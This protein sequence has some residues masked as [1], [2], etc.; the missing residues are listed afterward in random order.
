MKTGISTM[1]SN[2]AND[3]DDNDDDDSRL[4]GQVK[5]SQTVL[6]TPPPPTMR[7]AINFSKCHSVTRLESVF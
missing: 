1:K 7:T 6:S 5:S 3:D 4:K 2:E